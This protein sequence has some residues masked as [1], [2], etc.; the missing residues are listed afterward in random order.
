MSFLTRYSSSLWSKLAEIQQVE[1]L[2][3]IKFRWKNDEN[4]KYLIQQDCYNQAWFD[5]MSFWVG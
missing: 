4:E 3:K 5:T 1:I 2:D